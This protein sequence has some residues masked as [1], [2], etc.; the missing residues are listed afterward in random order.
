MCAHLWG[1]KASMLTHTYPHKP[2]SSHQADSQLMCGLMFDLDLVISKFRKSMVTHD[3]EFPYW[4]Q[5]SLNNT[6]QTTM[7]QYK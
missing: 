6:N 3:A 2:L 7:C 4:D 5:V 1:D